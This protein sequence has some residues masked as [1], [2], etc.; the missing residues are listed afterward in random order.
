MRRKEQEARIEQQ[1]QEKEK[2]RE[3]AARERARSAIPSHPIPSTTRLVTTDLEPSE[4]LPWWI[5]FGS[6]PAGAL[7]F[8][9]FSMCPGT[10]RSA[11]QR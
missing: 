11:W 2:A 7:C 5:D 6:V 1:R 10:E 8:C 4:R 9:V 3:D